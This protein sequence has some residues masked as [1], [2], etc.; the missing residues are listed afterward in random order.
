MM[1]LC[2]RTAPLGTRSARDVKI[3]IEGAIGGPLMTIYG[4]YP[5]LLSAQAGNLV[6]REAKWQ[7]RSRCRGDR[8][9]ASKY[10]KMTFYDRPSH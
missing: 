6:H 9:T 1:T 8:N 4:K 7:P 3:S 10:P 5:S 2:G